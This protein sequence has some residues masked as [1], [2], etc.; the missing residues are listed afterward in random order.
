MFA[1]FPRTSK[2]HTH[3]AFC[4]VRAGFGNSKFLWRVEIKNTGLRSAC[5]YGAESLECCA[6][7]KAGRPSTWTSS[8][9]HDLTRSQPVAQRMS[10]RNQ[11]AA[12]QIASA[13]PK[14]KRRHPTGRSRDVLIAFSTPPLMLRKPICE[15]EHHVG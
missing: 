5:W 10:S 3:A 15:M 12:G 14:P 7:K 6:V 9:S 2:L 8:T 11:S 1:G 4:G 13:I